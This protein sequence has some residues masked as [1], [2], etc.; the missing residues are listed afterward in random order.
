[1]YLFIILMEFVEGLLEA[2]RHIWYLGRKTEHTWIGKDNSCT[3]TR[4]NDWNHD[5]PLLRPNTTNAKGLFD[6]HVWRVIHRAAIFGAICT[7]LVHVFTIGTVLG[8]IG[9]YGLGMLFYHL[10]YNKLYY[11]KWLVDRTKIDPNW[12]FYN[13]N[14]TFLRS[15]NTMMIIKSVLYFVL[16]VFSF[17]L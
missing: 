3:I 16:I 17:F 13:K 14:L 15:T 6:M 4:P 12:Y 1:M 10:G 11:S 9:A 8:I 7:A 2:H 5:N